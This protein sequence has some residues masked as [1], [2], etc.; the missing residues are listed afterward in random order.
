M[1]KEP[2]PIIRITEE[3]VERAKRAR[4]TALDQNPQVRA[5]EEE[6]EKHRKEAGRAGGKVVL[7]AAAKMPP[8]EI[9]EYLVDD[10]MVPRVPTF[11]LTPR[12]SLYRESDH[13]EALINVYHPVFLYKSTSRM[14]TEPYDWVENRTCFDEQ[15]ANDE[16]WFGGL[17]VA[18]PALDYTDENRRLQVAHVALRYDLTSFGRRRKLNLVFA[19]DIEAMPTYESQLLVYSDY[20]QLSE[21]ILSSGIKRFYVEIESIG[22][23]SMNIYFISAKFPNSSRGGTW[24]FR[25]ISGYVI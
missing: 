18:D 16:L 7:D 2:V 12:E 17:S 3:Q 25:G 4:K 22:S 13:N 10:R 23:D 19:Y 5:F 24:F 8:R 14:V 15:H 1:A 20:E 6:L 9:P 11:T 21:Q